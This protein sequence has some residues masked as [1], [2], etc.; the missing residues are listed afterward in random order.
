MLCLLGV[1]VPGLCSLAL[2]A[3]LL[4]LADAEQAGRAFAAYGGI[5]ILASLAWLM[6]V[7]NVRPDLWDMIGA[8]TCIA[9]AMII[10]WGPRAG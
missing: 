2:F 3:Y 6:I 10:L 4:T 7:E 9:G 8:A 5:Y 1:L